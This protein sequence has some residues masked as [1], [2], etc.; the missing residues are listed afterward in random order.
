MRFAMIGCLGIAI[1]ILGLA[2]PAL[3]QNRPAIES[4]FTSIA[5]ADCVE[6]GNGGDEIDF[7]DY[8]CPGPN[9]MS[10]DLHFHD[11]L[12]L[13][14]G[15]N[16]TQVGSTMLSSNRPSNW[17]VDWRGR[18]ENGVFRP[19]AAIVRVRDPDWSED[20]SGSYL[21]VFG[22]GPHPCLL[23]ERSGPRANAEARTLADTGH[24]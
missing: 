23:G 24:C 15:F 12:Y 22:F 21:L 16:G 20:H 6:V 19:L 5:S 4:R 8:R 17:L 11:S 1:A 14:L 10:V 9:G 7:V 2:T 3:S 13:A 18:V